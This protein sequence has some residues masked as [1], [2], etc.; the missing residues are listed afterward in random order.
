MFY[1]YQSILNW[2]VKARQNL[3]ESDLNIF[4]KQI[5]IHLSNVEFEIIVANWRIWT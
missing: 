4:Y 2:A 5:V 3:N 1:F